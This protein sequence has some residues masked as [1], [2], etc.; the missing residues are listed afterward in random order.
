MHGVPTLGL[1]TRT[2]H[3]RG[4]EPGPVATGSWVV[5]LWKSGCRLSVDGEPAFSLLVLW[6]ELKDTPA[7][8][9]PWCSGERQRRWGRG[10]GPPSGGL[11]TDQHCGAT[12]C[13]WGAGGGVPGEV[14]ALPGWQPQLLA[15]KLVG[16][17]SGLWAMEVALNPAAP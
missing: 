8:L 5:M 12:E 9:S 13:A 16:Q 10:V 14:L 3:Q 4:S 6:Q 7:R 17:S 1:D 11:G 2:G 15:R